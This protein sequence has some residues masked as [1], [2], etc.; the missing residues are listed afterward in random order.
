MRMETSYVINRY[1]TL[2]IYVFSLNQLITCASF[3][4]LGSLAGGSTGDS[5]GKSGGSVAGSVTNKNV[6]PRIFNHNFHDFLKPFDSSL[7]SMKKVR[8]DLIKCKLV[9][10]RMF[11]HYMIYYGQIM[12]GDLYYEL[13]GSPNEAYV[14]L[15]NAD[16]NNIKF[17]ECR[18][19]GQGKHGQSIFDKLYI[20][21]K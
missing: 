6:S 15:Y 4:G 14:D 18:D 20:G 1:I 17:N 10:N 12:G 8:G 21:L 11:A 5:V 13:H 19:E 3:E 2:L 7:E 9:H 16:P